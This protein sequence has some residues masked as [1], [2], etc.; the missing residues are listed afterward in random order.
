ME[1][2][3]KLNAA[4]Y[5]N[6]DSIV[7]SKLKDLPIRSGQQDF[8]YVVSINEGITQ[9]EL[10]EHLYIGKST[11]AKAIKNLVDSGYIRKEKDE[12]DKRSDRLYLTEKGREISPRIQQGFI[13]VVNVAMK[14][15]SDEEIE[16]S[17]KLLNK[18]LNNVHKKKIKINSNID[19]L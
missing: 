10:S 6:M 16:T 19:E 17:I 13:E 8:F 5:R 4:I 1:S 2:I 3:G 11:T 12:K 7:N 14:D 15:L 9:K 18:I